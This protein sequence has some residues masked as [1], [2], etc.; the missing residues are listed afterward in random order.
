VHK[1]YHGTVN[2]LTATGAVSRYNAD[3]SQKTVTVFWVLI[4]SR[5]ALCPPKRSEGACPGASL[6]RICLGSRCK[7][8]N[9]DEQLTHIVR[10]S[11]SDL[12]FL[13]WIVVLLIC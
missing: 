12:F 1:T 11:V 7:S 3:R 8:K 13:S 4:A 2:L 9:H 10:V 6:S 5:C